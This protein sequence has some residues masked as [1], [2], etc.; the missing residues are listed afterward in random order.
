MIIISIK[1]VKNKANVLIKFIN[2]EYIESTLTNG[3]F[4]NTLDT[5]KKSEGLT[6][7]QLDVDEG[8]SVN[9]E[10]DNKGIEIFDKNFNKVGDLNPKQIYNFK[11]KKS[12]DF[13][14]KVPICL[15]MIYLYD[16]FKA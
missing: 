16:I 3:F 2:E 5:F 15:T 4:F 9:F 1:S 8:C 12:Y 7:N 14:L 11:L 6:D 10:V 13:A